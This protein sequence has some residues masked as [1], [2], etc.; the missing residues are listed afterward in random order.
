VNPLPLRSQPTLS[1]CAL[2]AVRNEAHYL[3]H[4]LPRLAGESIDVVLIDNGSNDDSAAL[5]ARHMGN[6]IL[7]VVNLPYR[8]HFSLSEQ[9]GIKQQV[10]DRLPH[11]WILHHD[12]DEILEHRESGK[13]L[14]DAIEE[15]DAA[16]ANAL[17]FEEF[18][19]LPE[20]GAPTPPLADYSRHL[21]YYFFAPQSNRLNRAW[22]RRTPL[23][24]HQSGGHCL[25]GDQ[26]RLFPQNHILRHFIVLSQAH[27]LEKYLH[28]TFDPRDL[29]YQWH[30]NRLSFTSDNLRIPRASPYL[31]TLPAPDSKAFVRT[32]PASK[33]F[34][35]WTDS[36]C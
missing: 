25:A 23:S 32:A 3:R 15:A 1:I 33:H 29:G 21:R 14:R 12:A 28:R 24:N 30:G 9:L 19:F 36:S 27:A 26:L 5:Y 13:S 22:K 34:W 6:P 31:H 18:V 8:G 20:P 11:D 17:N 16:G 35:E 10:Q 2:L 7:Q 4:L